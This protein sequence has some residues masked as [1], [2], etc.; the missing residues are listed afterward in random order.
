LVLELN[1]KKQL[2]TEGKL[3]KFGKP[4]ENTPKDWMT[5][6]KDYSGQADNTTTTTTTTVLIK[7]EKDVKVEVSENDTEKK[8]EKKKKKK[9]K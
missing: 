3:D 1:K 7:E 2:I 6:Y 5:S 8:K 9:L 4:N